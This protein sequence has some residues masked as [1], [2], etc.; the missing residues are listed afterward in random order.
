MIRREY[1]FTLI[2]M[3]LVVAITAITA[4]VVVLAIPH[5]SGQQ[6]TRRQLSQLADT[7]ILL[8]DRAVIEGQ[9]FG[10]QIDGQRYRFM[11]LIHPGSGPCASAPQEM[12]RWCPYSLPRW[13]TEDVFDEGLTVSL[14]LSGLAL[15]EDEAGADGAGMPQVLLLP[16]GEITPFE[17]T[18][19]DNLTFHTRLTI[20]ETGKAE[21]TS[22]AGEALVTGGGR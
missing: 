11:T 9:I 10:L 21:I 19:S 3:M 12:V 8:R 22:T 7:L 1:G 6:E 14:T 4:S 15:D 13:H 20:G 17:M 5:T 2:E 16:G 18:V